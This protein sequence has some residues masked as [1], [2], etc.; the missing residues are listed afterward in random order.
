MCIR[1]C[2][3]DRG[4]DIPDPETL[5]SLGKS[6]I[7][8]K[9]AVLQTVTSRAIR[10]CTIALPAFF[11]YGFERMNLIPKNRTGRFFLEIAVVSWSMFFG[12]S[13]SFSAFNPQLT[14]KAS[15]LEPEFHHIIDKNVGKPY[16]EFKFNAGL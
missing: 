15:D 12:C 13:L 3:L 1:K 10:S 6:R 9:K 8:A 16:S 4:I 11:L 14:V 7:A 2:E 5:E